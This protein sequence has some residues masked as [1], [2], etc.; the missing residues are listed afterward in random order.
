M[1]AF[2]QGF[3]KTKSIIAVKSGPGALDSIRF[4]VTV[5]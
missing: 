2:I 5:P 1:L 3:K 4:R